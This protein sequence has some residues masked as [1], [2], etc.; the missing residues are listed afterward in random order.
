[1]ARF[2]I[3]IPDF[4]F[5]GAGSA[6]LFARTVEVARAAEDAGFTSLWV[7]DHMHQLPP[8][9]PRD[10]PMPEGW[11]LLGGLAAATRTIALG[12]LVTGALYRNPALLAKMATTLDVV[13]GGRAVLGLGA[14][15]QEDEYRAYGF[16]DALP[17]ARER[18]DRLED[19][20]RIARAMFRGGEAVVIGRRT[21]VDGALNV[22]APVQPHGPRILVGG[23]GERRLLRLVAE[24]A[25]MCNVFGSPAAVAH[26]LAVLDA[27]CEAVGRDPREITRTRLGMLIVDDSAVAADARAARQR[28]MLGGRDEESFRAM[29][30]WGTPDS[31]RVQVEAYLAAGLDEMFFFTDGPWSARSVRAAGDALGALAD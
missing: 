19:A 27:H 8:L 25:D 10:A 6:D 5:P 13:S 23:S 3:Q 28:E 26:K 7:M 29:A 1:M 17:G 14:G 4:R 11:V 31:V 12:T 16:G 2:G 18:L 30:V 9:I 22:P 15:W 20:L 24:H 21:S